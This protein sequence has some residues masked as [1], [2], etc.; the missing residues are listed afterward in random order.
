MLFLWATFGSSC[1]SV[2]FSVFKLVILLF[3]DKIT[4]Y[5]GL[6]NF[7]TEKSFTDIETKYKF[8]D[9][10]EIDNLKKL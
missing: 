4:L 7:L 9:R 3:D 1:F 5:Y 2:I 6:L 10:I 8:P